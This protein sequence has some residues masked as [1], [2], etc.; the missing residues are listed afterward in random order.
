LITLLTTL[1]ARI[2]PT[3]KANPS[4]MVLPKLE[5]GIELVAGIGGGIGSF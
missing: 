4:V 2:V 1:E 3:L 5:E